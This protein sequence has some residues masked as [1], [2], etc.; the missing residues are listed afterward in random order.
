[1]VII[2]GKA[3]LSG[4]VRTVIA[5]GMVGYREVNHAAVAPAMSDFEFKKRGQEK[6]IINTFYQEFINIGINVTSLS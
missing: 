1:M 3:C 5:G 2:A 4:A 6:E